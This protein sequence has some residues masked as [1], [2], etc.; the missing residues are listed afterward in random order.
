ML[1]LSPEITIYIL[2]VAFVLGAVF[3]SFIGC[4]GWRISKGESVMK[5]RSHCDFCGHIL[6]GR[7]LIPIISYL[8]RGGRCAYCK[9]P[10]PKS[11]LWG[12]ILMALLFVGMTM[13]YDVTAE[14][15]LALIFVCILYL[16]TLTDFYI[17]IIPNGCLLTAIIARLIYYFFIE[18][19]QLNTMLILLG[20]AL[21]I[22]LPLL[23][24]TLLMEKILKKE[25][26]GG[27]DIKLIFVTGMYLGW[28]Q[29]LL[30]LFIA[31]I[32]GIVMS[33]GN[34]EK[35]IPFGPAIAVATVFTML[36]GEGVLTWYLSLF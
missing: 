13:R 15:V 2:S 20:N 1:Y 35:V 30:M 21:S 11:S 31:C 36:I 12:E 17:Q 16:L 14:L 19:F 9:S 5:G 33:L 27:G 18:G 6:R 29:N 10:I 26:M 24:L 25:A 23:L 28:E 8:A 4:M 3:A 22:S 32:L 34:K 7:D